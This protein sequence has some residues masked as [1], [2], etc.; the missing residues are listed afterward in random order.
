[1]VKHLQ[2]HNVHCMHSTETSIALPSCNFPIINPKKKSKLHKKSEHRTHD[3]NWTQKL[4]PTLHHL[5]KWCRITRSGLLDQKRSRHS[6]AFTSQNYYFP[7]DPVHNI[8]ILRTVMSEM[9][10]L[11]D[12]ESHASFGFLSRWLTRQII[13]FSISRCCRPCARKVQQVYQ[14][15]LS[16]QQYWSRAAITGKCAE[17]NIFILQWQRLTANWPFPRL[18]TAEHEQ[19]TDD[20]WQKNFSTRGE[21]SPMSLCPL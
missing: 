17:P 1:M 14:I 3:S 9:H 5:T 21:P 11:L 16:D 19:L 8:W 18:K 2:P 15:I 13:T 4:L 12:T 7:S 6:P 10:Y 20:N